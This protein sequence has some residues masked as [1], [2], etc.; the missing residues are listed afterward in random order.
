M[1]IQVASDPGAFQA[2][3]QAGWNAA[4]DSYESVMGPLTVQSAEST[5]DAA[6]VTS[7]CRVLDVCTGHGVL[8]LLASRR[9]AK[10][11]ALDF[12]EAMVAAARRNVPT[13]DCR[14]GD[15]QDLPYEDNTFDAVVCG[16]GL[17][18]VPEPD[19][20]LT[21]MRRVLRPGGRAAISVWERPS[22]TNGLGLLLGALR[23]HGRLDVGLPHGPD[24]FQFGDPEHMKAALASV[25]FEDVKAATVAQGVALESPEG[26]MDAV[27]QGSVRTKALLLAQEE[28]ALSA[29]N[30]AVVQGMEKLY[31]EEG[32]GFRVP[33]PAV[34]GSGARPR[35]RA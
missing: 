13:A 16:Y 32:G 30:A 28:A 7:G 24:M 1:P 31:R 10:V 19:R 26:L 15:A 9:G 34:V 27:L 3:E 35:R 22:P 25:G 5:L 23:T 4:S 12:A 29:I 6:G 17:I 33:M 11:S 18:H 14:I 2:F 20:A 21:E 8:S